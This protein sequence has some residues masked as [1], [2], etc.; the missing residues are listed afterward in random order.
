MWTVCGC[1][2][3]WF[4]WISRLLHTYKQD[5]TSTPPAVTHTSDLVAPWPWPFDLQNLIVS[6]DASSTSSTRVWWNSV[7]WF[8]LRYRANRTH[9][10]K[11]HGHIHGSTHGRT[12]Q[13][14][15]A[16]AATIGGGR[17]H[18][19]WPARTCWKKSW[20]KKIL[21]NQIFWFKSDFFYLNQIFWFS[22]YFRAKVLPNFWNWSVCSITQTTW[23]SCFCYF[24]LYSCWTKS[25]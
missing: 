19:E 7:H 18:K 15:N 25:K 6:S 14:H 3:R 23:P 17:Q 24:W 12:T 9:A 22:L 1:I 2:P 16:S 5:D 13:K 4:T 11:E 20:F 10:R 8:N 21:K